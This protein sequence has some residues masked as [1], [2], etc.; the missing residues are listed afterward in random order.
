MLIVWRQSISWILE[1]DQLLIGK[2]SGF[3]ERFISGKL[4]IFCWFSTG[5]N[6]SIDKMFAGNWSGLSMSSLIGNYRFFD[7]KLWIKFCDS[8]G[9]TRNW[10]WLRYKFI[11]DKVS[12][13]GGPSISP[14]LENNQTPN[15]NFSLNSLLENYRFFEN[16]IG[17]I[18]EIDQ[19]L[20]GNSSGSY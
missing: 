17:S 16:T 18:L 4:W 8:I 15:Q 3:Y 10:F 1:N 11:T 2:L 7:G 19:L 13:L 6:L 20:I 12:V 5:S 9:F 14:I